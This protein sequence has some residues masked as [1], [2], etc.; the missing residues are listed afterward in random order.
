MSHSA[1]AWA[2]QQKGLKP[3]TKI[4]LYYLSD[5]H[6]HETGKC[7]PSLNYLAKRCEMDRSTVIKHIDYLVSLGL[8][9]K[10]KERRDDNG[11][12]SNSYVL[13]F[14]TPLL[15]NT[16]R[17]SGKTQLPLVGKRDTNLGSNNLGSN[18]NNMRTFEK[19]W[20][21]YPKKKGKD[22]AIKAWDKVCKDHNVDEVLCALENHNVYWKGI[23]SQ[24]IPYPASWL[25]GKRW[26]DEL[27]KP[28]EN[29]V[30]NVAAAFLK[31][32]L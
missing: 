5:C 2:M 1:T 22:K 29:T 4:V 23:D 13:N 20:N 9:S 31:G 32:E 30:V 11:W 12:A 28:Q 18:N 3:T 15:E 27:E 25:N 6:N 14:R 17:A 19:F 16:T 21:A 10:N 24:F 8:I 26:E 7:F